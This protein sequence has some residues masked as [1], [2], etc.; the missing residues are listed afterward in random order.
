MYDLNES[1]LANG[2][3]SVFS[4]GQ[5]ALSLRADCRAGYFLRVK[6]SA[7]GVTVEG[8]HSGD[9]V[10]TNLETGEIDLSEWNGTRQTF[11]IRLSGAE[12]SAR[13]LRTLVLEVNNE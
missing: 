10:W 8:R 2:S 11:E 6:T 5:T 1:P 7:G 9:T 3:V 13:A 4:G 12:V